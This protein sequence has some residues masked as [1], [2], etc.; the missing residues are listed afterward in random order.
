MISKKKIKNKTYLFVF[1]MIQFYQEMMPVADFFKKKGK[2]VF[3]LFGW[4][5][6]QTEVFE[7]KLNN[8]GIIVGYY[9]LKLLRKSFALKRNLNTSTKKKGSVLLSLIKSYN[10]NKKA[11]LF[12]SALIKQIKPQAIFDGPYWGSEVNFA[13]GIK[14]KEHN[15]LYCH[16]PVFAFL[17]ETQFGVRFRVVMQPPNYSF[18]SKLLNKITIIFFPSLKRKYGDK[19]YLPHH[20]LKLLIFWLSGMKLDDPWKIPT[21]IYDLIFVEANYISNNLIKEGY[22][23]SQI[24]NVGKPSLDSVKKNISNPKIVKTLYS[25]IGLNKNENF[26]LTFFPPYAEHGILSW[27]EHEVLLKKFISSFSNLKMKTIFSLHPASAKNYY[28]E[29]FNNLNFLKIIQ[30]HTFHEYLPLST[31]LVLPLSSSI[32][33]LSFEFKKKLIIY[34]FLDKRFKEDLTLAIAL[35]KGAIFVDNF[36]QLKKEVNKNFLVNKNYPSINNYKFEKDSSC[37]E[38]FKVVNEYVTKI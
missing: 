35:E 17:G 8:Q 28:L 4:K 12:A 36:K 32:I 13:I 33:S 11:L 34:D 14:A 16:L 19:S 2:N 1:P 3:V 23:D 6:E 10:N 20:P 26:L 15:I 24:L 21:K 9:P 29:N 18:L 7:K 37:K 5:D 27:E 31:G 30:N 22:K 25:D 38:I